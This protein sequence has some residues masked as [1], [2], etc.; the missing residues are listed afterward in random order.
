MLGFDSRTSMP[1][2]FRRQR[3]TEERRLRSLLDVAPDAMVVVDQVGRVVLVNTQTE[4]LFG[5]QQEEIVGHPVEVLIPER[6]RERHRGH[7][8]KFSAEPRVRPMG[9]KLQLFGLRKDGTEFPVEISLSPIETAEGI[10]VASAIR[11]ITERKLAEESRLRLATIV[12]SSDDAIISENLDAV[13]ESWNAGAQRI[14][15]Y[16]ETEAIGQPIT[17]LIPSELRDEENKILEKL[18]AGERIEHYETIRVTKTGNR[19][20]VSLTI[21]PTRDSTGKMVGFSKI[22]RDITERK[23]AEAAIRASEERLRLAQQAARIGTFEW[24]IQTGVN[25]WTPELEAMYGLPRGGF[26]GTQT[27]FENL[28]HP[29]DRA[30]VIELNNCALKT[31]QPTTGE[32]R[33]VWPDGSVHWIAGRWQVLRNDSG[34]PSRMIGVNIDVTES[35]RAEQA[36]QEMNR[37]LGE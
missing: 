25:T 2:K 28:V 22:A 37:A 36:L 31:G 13:I 33:V 10:L 14:F 6:F 9:A 34:E 32:W 4:K 11:D 29:D 15:G 12:Q 7:R 30:R 8:G 5:Y 23:R 3:S 20:S 35:K 1:T 21:S 17:I 27:A 18:R 19:V 24:N 16:T 26:G